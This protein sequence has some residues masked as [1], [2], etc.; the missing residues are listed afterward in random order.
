MARCAEALAHTLLTFLKLKVSRTQNVMFELADR[1]AEV[2]HA[3]ALCRRAAGGS[4]G[5]QASC[6]LFARETATRLAAS[7]AQLISASAVE[8]EVLQ[9]FAAQADL[10]RLL[11]HRAGSQA[12]MDQVVQWVLDQPWP[13]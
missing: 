6:R 7:A 3:M 4:E 10:D 12:D 8:P 13:G 5:L 2:E 9:A 11:F 1:I